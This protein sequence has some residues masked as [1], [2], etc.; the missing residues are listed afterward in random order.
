MARESL[1]GTAQISPHGRHRRGGHGND[2]GARR[3]GDRPDGSGA[4][5]AHD[6]ELPQ[7]ARHAV[8]RLR[9]AGQDRGRGDRQQVPDPHLR[10]R[11]DRPGPPGH[12]CRAERHR[13]DGPYRL[14]LFLRQGPDLR[15]GHRHP[16][17]PEHAPDEL[18]AD[19]GRR[20]RDAQRV[21]Q[22]LQRPRHRLRQH[23]GTDGR[24]VPQGDQDARRSQGAE[25]PHR[26]RGRR[27][28][29]QARRGAAAAGRRRHLS[30]VGEGHD[31]CRRVGRSV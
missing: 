3:P 31:R 9:T 29:C 26:R 14:L 8:W 10:G 6:V 27:D 20:Q 5:L 16:V 19:A 30:G 7:V 11:R 2:G 22:G 28:P 12:R 4:E 17:R 15:A 21:L 25:V 18:L 13:R 24:L 1:H 23:D